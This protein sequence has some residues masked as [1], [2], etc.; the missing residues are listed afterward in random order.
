MRALYKITNKLAVW[1]AVSV[2]TTFTVAIYDFIA[3]TFHYRYIYPTPLMLLIFIFSV[4]W[5]M[6]TIKNMKKITLCVNK[7]Y[8]IEKVDI[9]TNDHEEIE[10][11][12]NYLR[13]TKASC[14]LVIDYL[15]WEEN[16]E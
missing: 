2:M 7:G 1:F 10:V 11:I 16:N 8:K 14:Q 6:I 3:F 9:F 12:S 4:S 13:K 15:E 5:T